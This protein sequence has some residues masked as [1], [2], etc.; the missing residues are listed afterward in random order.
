MCVC[1]PKKQFMPSKIG[2][3]P[4]HIP[5]SV[6]FKMCHTL[7]QAKTKGGYLVWCQNDREGTVAA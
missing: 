5:F 2:K 3:V 4:S 6:M 1:D 7:G